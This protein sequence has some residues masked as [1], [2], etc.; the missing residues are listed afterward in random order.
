M[1]A[2][3]FIEHCA[4]GLAFYI[5]GELQ[6]HTAD[7]QIYH[8]YLVV[9]A[10]ALAVK[11]FLSST[12][13][14]ETPLK[15]SLNEG[16]RVLICGGGDGLAARD[17]LR[18]PEV[19]HI[20]LVDYN[21]EVIELGKTVFVPFNHNSLT[22]AKVNIHIQDA[23]SFLANLAEQKFDPGDRY[24]VAICDF[25]YPTST[26]ETRIHSQEWFQL[27]RRVLHPQG[28][29][30]ENAVSP[31]LNT[32]GFWCLYQTLWSAGLMVKPMQVRIPSFHQHGY[33]DWGFLLAATDRTITKEELTSIPLPNGLRSLTLDALLSAFSFPEA[34]AARRFPVSI[35]S[36]QSPQLLYYLLNPHPVN[37]EIAPAQAEQGSIDFLE[38]DEVQEVEQMHQAW[39]RSLVADPLQLESVARLWLEQMQKSHPDFEKLLPVQH[40]YHTPK[41]TAAW[42]GSVPQLLAQIN[43]PRLIDRA[44]ARGKDLPP[45]VMA[46]LKQLLAH[47]QPGDTKESDRAELDRINSEQSQPSTSTKLLI[48]LTV[49]MLVANLVAP[50]SVFAKGSG[51]YSSGDGG[52]GSWSW[53]LTGMMMTIIGFVW[54]SNLTSNSDSN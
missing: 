20:D 3:L 33:G 40:S 43:L 50:D 42:L 6:F 34:I 39:M 25:T 30:A 17:V 24:H 9:P 54:L 7:E 26:E 52:D 15:N 51:Y 2:S 47:L 35:H 46:D 1:P 21:P 32:L 13:S 18:F 37:T 49:T 19:S 44:I 53:G 45:Q 29:V 22:H 28:I 12:N 23:F 48:A 8:E 41:M 14:Q 11:R 16:L 38:L 36:L 5:N 10:I 27:V 31:D 4:N